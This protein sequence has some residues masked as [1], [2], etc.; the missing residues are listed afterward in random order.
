MVSWTFRMR[1]GRLL[2][3]PYASR[4]APLPYPTGWFMLVPSRDVRRGQV[5]TCRLMGEDV[6]VY[7]TRSGRVRAARPYCPHLG[8][9]LG[10]GGRVDGELIVCP[11]HHFAFDGAGAV[12]RLGPGYSGNPVRKGLGVLPC[13]EVNGG[14]FAWVGARPDEPPGWHIP[15]LAPSAAKVR[16]TGCTELATHPQEISENA[17]DMGHVRALHGYPDFSMP[18]APVPQGPTYTFAFRVTRSFPLFGQV[19][20]DATVT[21]YGLGLMH[22]IFQDRGQGWQMDLLIMSCPVAPWRTQVTIG[23]RIS[24]DTSHGRWAALPALATRTLGAAATRVNLHAAQKDLAPDFPIWNTKRYISPPGLAHGD[25][26][27]GAYRTWAQQFYPTL[28][29]S[30]PG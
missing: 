18:R 12:A 4:Q 14:I 7:R 10:C 28:R 2:Q 5:R 16:F 9:H 13:E 3:E 17:V 6:V 23:S 29:V 1:P 25:G 15:S 26:P 30:R 11:F 24:F 8:A 19:V 21:L 20:A 22:G 27:I